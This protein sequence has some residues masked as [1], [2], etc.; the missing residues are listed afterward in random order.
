MQLAVR[1]M[2][3]FVARDLLSKSFVSAI[4]ERLGKNNVQ[5]VTGIVST[6][7]EI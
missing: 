7:S 1:N 6:E 5:L 3:N 4:D 2:A